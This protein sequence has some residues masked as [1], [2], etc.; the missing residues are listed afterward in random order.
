MHVLYY[1][2]SAFTIN[3]MIHLD[4]TSKNIQAEYTFIYNNPIQNSN[5][6]FMNTPTAQSIHPSIKEHSFFN[7]VDDKS[8]LFK[9]TFPIFCY[10]IRY[11]YFW[12][13]KKN[14]VPRMLSTSFIYTS[15][16]LRA[17]PMTFTGV[18]CTAYNGG[19]IDV[20]NEC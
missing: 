18:L 17:E 1:S 20:L 5:V 10:E 3:S 11:P 19:S 6:H 7:G 8:K 13:E 14:S 4:T 16:H 12:R 9:Q 15:P 2:V